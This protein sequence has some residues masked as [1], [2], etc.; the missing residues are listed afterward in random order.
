MAPQAPKSPS[1]DAA[2]WADHAFFLPSI[3]LGSNRHR[4]FSRL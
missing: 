2:S 4:L 1:R 3:A